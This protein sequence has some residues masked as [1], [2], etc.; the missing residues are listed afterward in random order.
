MSGKVLQSLFYEFKGR[1]LGK[2]NIRKSVAARMGLSFPK[3]SKE[4]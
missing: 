4:V 2:M 1:F 3:I